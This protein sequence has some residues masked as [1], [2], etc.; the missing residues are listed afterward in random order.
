MKEP[1]PKK[2]AQTVDAMAVD[3][4]PET[5]AGG[6]DDSLAGGGRHKLPPEELQRFDP[7]KI[8]GLVFAYWWLI[9]LFVLL[10]AGG[11]AAYC[12]LGTPKFR[13]ACQYQIF[14][15]WALSMGVET[16]LEQRTRQMDRQITILKS[17]ILRQ[18]VRN[19]LAPEWENRIPTLEVVVEV[20]QDRR[21]PV[22]SIVVDSVDQD[23]GVAFLREVVAGYEEI[24]RLEE[25]EAT[26]RSLRS[27]RIEKDRLANEL[28]DGRERLRDFQQRHNIKISQVRS[29]YEETRLQNIMARLNSLRMESSMIEMQLAALQSANAAT[30]HDVIALN[31]ETH[32]LT[33]PGLGAGAGAAT[34]GGERPAAL[35]AGS[36]LPG[37]DG[38]PT[39]G[40][41]ESM[42]LPTAILG[43][44][45][46]GRN[47]EVYEESLARLEASYHE[48]LKH[49]KPS[50]PA[51][52][53]LKQRIS[54]VKKDIE[55]ESE[56]AKRRLQARYDALKI[57]QEA[58][59][60]TVSTWRDDINR[61][62]IAE[63]AEYGSI[64]GEVARLSGL[65]NQ[66]SNRIID[67]ASKSTESVITQLIAAPT[68]RGQ[69][70][71]KPLLV[72]GG[73]TGGAAA[74]GAALAFALFFFD[75]RFTDAVAL[76][77]RLQLP[78]ISG[79]P[80]W[81]RVIKDLDPDVSIVMD[82]EHPNAVSESYRCL[83]VNLERY[84]GEKR[85]YSLMLTSADAGEGKSITTAN[86]GIAFAWTGRKV[87]MLDADLRR[88][89]LH[90]AMGIKSSQVGFSQFLL[91]EVEDWHMLVEKTDFPNV[92]LI[93]AGRFVLEAPE[94]CSPARLRELLTE[95]AKE[96]DLIILD[97]APVGRIVDTAI[98]ARG[99]DGIMFVSLHGKTSVPAMR[100]SL[101]RLEGTNV[102][103]FCLNAIDM[104]RGH[105]YYYG[106]YYN[107]RW[108]YGLYSYYY[109]YS[110]SLYGYGYGD[111][112]GDYGYSGYGKKR[113]R[114]VG[115]GDGDTDGDASKQPSAGTG[116]EAAQP[117]QQPPA[118]A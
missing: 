32:A 1:E 92:D 67:V 41:A 50:H 62:S 9:L 94:L 76:E 63:A 28:Q 26:E 111:Q 12:V 14:T 115:E 64:Q 21:R 53:D 52:D 30:I 68:A 48:K 117:D 45:G 108:Q 72:M 96:Y 99:C 34:S 71:P 36:D 93:Q 101:K 103:G 13:A 25:M 22:L 43:G 102:L 84:M 86:L 31:L 70:W 55:F 59:D 49:Y 112:Y 116:D 17:D 113:Q 97:T 105:G 2:P 39:A 81:E 106:G 10:G 107:Y 19:K 104:P 80:R 8:I 47:W 110:T 98:M 95:M 42:R 11:G 58:L 5:A 74:L 56:L 90:N 88:P 15:E 89:N 4:L 82:K 6:V 65:V 35:A 57:Q 27:L 20:V 69:V 109:Y 29:Q 77:H 118:S 60:T 46:H 33:N 16:S 79:I 78:F 51:M 85:G 18:R 83:R 66:L 100:H 3:V 75:T 91:N 37:A 73:A 40:G 87:L 54:R 23:Y 24:R 7:R 44:S 114:Q 61:L 38:Q